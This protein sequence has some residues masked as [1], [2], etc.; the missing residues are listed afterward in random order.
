MIPAPGSQNPTPYL[1]AADLRNPYTSSFSA[2]DSLRSCTP[3]CLAWMRWSQWIV[4]GTATLSLRV[5][6]NWSIAVWAEN[7]LENHP[8]RARP[9]VRLG[10]NYILVFGI[11]EV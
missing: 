8:V 6:M 11:V 10:R 5:C 7:V 2:S 3:S 1:A 9:H 4:V